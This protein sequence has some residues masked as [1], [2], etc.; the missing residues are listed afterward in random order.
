M[1]KTPRPANPDLRGRPADIAARRQRRLHVPH[2]SRRVPEASWHVTYPRPV[3]QTWHA[4]A[5]QKGF[6]VHSRVR[7]RYHLALECRDCGGLTAHKVYTLRTA[8]PRCG[9]CAEAAL[10]KTARAAGLVFLRRAQTDHQ[11]GLYRAS[12]GHVVR[13]QFELVERIAA[14]RTHLRCAKCLV[15]RE[16]AEARRRG[17]MRL[18]RD[19]RGGPN[20]R[21]YR[22]H[23]GH[24][25]RV[26]RVNMAWGQCR[27][28]ACGGAWIAR[29]SFIYLIRIAIAEQ[30]LEL[31]KL[32]F[33][34]HP[35]KRL[36][37]QLGLP[38]GTKA[39][40]IRVLPIAT[41]HDACTQERAAHATLRRRFPEAVVPLET[42]A[43][44]LN[45]RSE[46]YAPQIFDE[47]MRLMDGIEARHART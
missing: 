30:G 21:L 32:G 47:I 40:L 10:A 36:R 42:I 5:A 3:P 2:R 19:P 38:R 41:G 22:H 16:E 4:I 7:D 43:G 11:Y 9:A 1:P 34:K 18:G 14:G 6:R 31:L 35:V 44:V 27:C 45:V 39:E 24:I 17:W 20:Y 33:S 37:H 8:R 15:A 12:C 46:V 23:C 25:Q 26:A 28:A 29:P 13:R